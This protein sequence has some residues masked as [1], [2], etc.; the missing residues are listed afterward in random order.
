MV[1]PDWAFLGGG[2][3]WRLL[4]CGPLG[5]YLMSVTFR[6][7]L[8]EGFAFAPQNIVLRINWEESK[9]EGYGVMCWINR[10]FRGSLGQLIPCALNM[11][12][13]SR[14]PSQHCPPADLLNSCGVSIVSDTQAVAF[15]PK[16]G[17]TRPMD[18]RFRSQFTS[19]LVPRVCEMPINSSKAGGHVTQLTR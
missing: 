3:L 13:F 10:R 2:G 4:G 11:P 6:S 15:T 1:G 18:T 8:A 5:P 7:S 17:A 16:A 12:Y 9:A 19:L 14:T